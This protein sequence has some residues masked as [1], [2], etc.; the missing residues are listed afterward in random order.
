MMSMAK[1][2]CKKLPEK[3]KRYAR[4]STMPGMVLVTSAIPSTIFFH[5]GLMEL[6]AVISA[7]P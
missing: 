6:L 3:A 7:A 1:V 4:P 5:F 2:F